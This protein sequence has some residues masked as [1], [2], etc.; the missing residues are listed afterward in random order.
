[1]SSLISEEDLR[2]LV[3]QVRR[4]T[5]SVTDLNTLLRSFGKEQGILKT[6][7]KRIDK[8]VEKM[9]MELSD[10][11][12]KMI[13]MAKELQDLRGE[14]FEKKG[15]SKRRKVPRKREEETFF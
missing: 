3:D 8:I 13:K 5:Q 4:N 10:M 6:K 1:M 2:R 15:L 7:V 11:K 14:I 9:E 12:T